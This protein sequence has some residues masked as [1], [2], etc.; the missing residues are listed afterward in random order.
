MDQDGRRRRQ[1]ETR[2]EKD[3]EQSGEKWRG[4]ENRAEK[5]GNKV[6]TRAETETEQS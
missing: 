6:E 4:V 3:G 5:G 2:V 1:V